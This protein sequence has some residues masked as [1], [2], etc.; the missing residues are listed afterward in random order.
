MASRT[1]VMLTPSRSAEF[2][3][4]DHRARSQPPGHDLL[5]QV[6]RDGLGASQADGSTT[7]IAPSRGVARRTSHVPAQAGHYGM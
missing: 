5:A 2:S 4:L 7:Q 6:P 1:G 3:V